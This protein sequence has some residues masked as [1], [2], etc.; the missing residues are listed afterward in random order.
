VR[1]PD[2]ERLLLDEMFAPLIAQRLRDENFDV[3][4]VAEDR[5]LRAC[6]DATIFAWA[7]DEHRR[8]ATENVQH[9]DPLLTERV[10]EGLP[11]AG[12]L[13]T[14]S[15]TFKRSRTNPGPLVAALRAWLLD[16]NREPQLV[17]WLQPAPDNKA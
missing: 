15:R 13:F 5:Q 10:R 11:T 7:C 8:L 9:F 2:T 1:E 3:I 4:S 14:S 6:S 12:V 17:E 16:T